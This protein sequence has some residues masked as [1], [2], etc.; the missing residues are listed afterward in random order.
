MLTTPIFWL[1]LI[2]F[3]IFVYYINCYCSIS[4]MTNSSGLISAGHWSV[5]GLSDIPN[6]TETDSVERGL[7]PKGHYC[8]EGSSTPT[9]CPMGTYGYVILSWYLGYL[10][11]NGLLKQQRTPQRIKICQHRKLI[12]CWMTYIWLGKIRIDI[13]C[14]TS[15]TKISMIN[16]LFNLFSKLLR[17]LVN[18]YQPLYDQLINH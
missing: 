16:H 6:P 3:L 17:R 8:L 15:K 4:G 10:K 13:V 14:W 11:N 1:R 7:C 5:T 2:I 18:C 12:C 9:P